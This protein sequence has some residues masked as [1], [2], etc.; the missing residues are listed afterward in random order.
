MAE[1]IEPEVENT[2][3]PA[4]GETTET[5]DEA[6]Q[7]ESVEEVEPEVE[8]PEL[9]DTYRGKS[10]AEVAKMHSELEKLMARQGNELA[11]LRQQVAQ[12]VVQAEPEPPS[13]DVDFFTNPKGAVT[14][15][16]EN[17]EVIKE[18]RQTTAQLKRDAGVQKLLAKHP[19]MSEIIN[20]DDFKEWSMA[21]PVR[22]RLR[23]EADQMFSVEAADELITNFKDI[24]GMAA[25]AKKAGGNA[26]KK[27]VQQ[28]NTGGASSNPDSVSSRKILNGAEIRQ[29]MK[30]DPA[31][32][33]A[34][35]EALMKAYAEDRVRG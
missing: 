14:Q 35:Q 30:T 15:T 2:E 31:W 23:Y 33:E 1:W 20:S 34:N 25:Q 17:H 28:A 16:L 27:A 32:Y 29:R 5:L 9:A 4:E 24:K 11:A 12:P 3:P 7:A 8:E 10:V 21:T 19:D 22:Q 13:E 18:F 6:L 26:R